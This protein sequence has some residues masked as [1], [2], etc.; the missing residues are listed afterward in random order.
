MN[1]SAQR[2]GAAQDAEGEKRASRVWKSA[3]RSVD[4]DFVGKNEESAPGHAFGYETAQRRDKTFQRDFVELARRFAVRLLSALGLFPQLDDL[5]P[6]QI[7]PG[8][9]PSLEERPVV[10]FH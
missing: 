10:R 4:V 7:L 6:D 8:I 5:E 9:H 3:P 1:V 2:I